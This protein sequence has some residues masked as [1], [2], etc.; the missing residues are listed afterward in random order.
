MPGSKSVLLG[1]V[2]HAGSPKLLVSVGFYSSSIVTNVY[3]NIKDIIY[4]IYLIKFLK[5]LGRTGAVV[6]GIVKFKSW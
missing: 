5:T 2:F 1:G 4:N 6:P 3:L